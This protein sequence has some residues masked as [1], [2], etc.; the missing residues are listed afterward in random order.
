MQ[1]RN[2]HIL[3]LVVFG[4]SVLFSQSGDLNPPVFYFGGKQVYAGMPKGE[5]LATLSVCCKLSPPAEPDVDKRPHPADRML[6]HFILPREESQQVILGAIY[7]LN[8]RVARISRDLS[9]NFDT[10]N[11]D[12]V[13]FMRAFK[14]SVPDGETS[15]V[16][17]LRHERM[18]NAE[19]QV[20][21]FVFPNGRGLEV[22]VATLDNGNGTRRDFVT[23]DETL[24][25]AGK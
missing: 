11:T 22:H 7:F 8:G 19:S 24:E 18:S 5:A 17:S 20:L 6:G 10:F 16:V 25:L 3:G 2:A 23:L 12:L 1:K 13:T 21:T 15:A 14:R 9:Q 4:S